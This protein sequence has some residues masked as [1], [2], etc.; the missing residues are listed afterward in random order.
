[1]VPCFSPC[2]ASLD[3]RSAETHPEAA[4]PVA[5]FRCAHHVRCSTPLCEIGRAFVELGKQLRHVRQGERLLQSVVAIVIV[6]AVLCMSISDLGMFTEMTRSLVLSSRYWSELN[7]A[8]AVVELERDGILVAKDEA[9]FP[10]HKQA[11]DL[12]HRRGLETETAGSPAERA[13]SRDQRC[14]EPH[15]NPATTLQ[16]GSR[17]LPERTAR[18]SRPLQPAPSQSPASQLAGSKQAP[19]DAPHKSAL[20]RLTFGVHRG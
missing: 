4:A 17:A 13:G 7:F 1:M 3:N 20:H 18:R 19:G 8:G 2:A 6:R 9:A 16:S 10:R 14:T 5:D 11:D 15:H 12:T